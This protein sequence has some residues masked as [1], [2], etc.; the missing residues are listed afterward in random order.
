MI[1]RLGFSHLTRTPEPESDL[2]RGRYLLFWRMGIPDGVADAYIGGKQFQSTVSRAGEE[3]QWQT[4][5]LPHPNYLSALILLEKSGTLVLK[6]FPLI[7]SGMGDPLPRMTS[8][9]S[10]AC[11]H[12]N[13]KKDTSSS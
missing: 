4:R 1:V 6:H 3:C 9:D 7:A 5:G 12:F 11:A 8:Y 10:T 2:G 13:R